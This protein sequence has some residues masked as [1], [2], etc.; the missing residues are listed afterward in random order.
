MQKFFFGKW[1]FAYKIRIAVEKN[2]ESPSKKCQS[3][4]FHIW[5]IY[6]NHFLYTLDVWNCM[7]MIFGCMELYDKYFWC[8][9]VNPGTYFGLNAFWPSAS[10]SHHQWQKVPCK[11]FGDSWVI[12]RERKN[13]TSGR[14]M[15]FEFFLMAKNFL[16]KGN[17]ETF[18]FCLINAQTNIFAHFSLLFSD[19][20]AFFFFNH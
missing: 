11:G 14:K 19:S 20:H 18:I 3:Y 1:L 5:K 12:N 10:H 16:K 17:T 13:V 7:I 4:N 9:E 8:M 6:G 15:F 2:L